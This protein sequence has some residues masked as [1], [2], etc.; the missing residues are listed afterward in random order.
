MAHID[1][2]TKVPIVWLGIVLATFGGGVFWLSSL[3]SQ[4]SL[5][6]QINA[7]QDIKLEKTQEYL[8]DIR[9]RLIRIETKLNK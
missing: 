7:S 1:E 4:V 9:E 6:A 8:V 3:Y 5:A 2:R